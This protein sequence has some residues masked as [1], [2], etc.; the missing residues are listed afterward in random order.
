MGKSK[1]KKHQ[2]AIYV[3]DETDFE[4]AIANTNALIRIGKSTANTITANPATNTYDYI[5]QEQPET[6]VEKYAYSMEHDIA[7]YRGNADYEWAFEKFYNADSGDNAKGYAIIVFYDHEQ[8]AGVYKAF[9]A[10][11]T[12]SV[13]SADWVTGVVNVSI[14]F[15]DTP[16]TGV[17]KGSGKP[18]FVASPKAPSIVQNENSV[19]IATETDGATLLY[20]VD[21]TD[22]VAHGTEYT[23]AITLTETCTVKAAALKDDAA[24]RVIKLYCEVAATDSGDTSGTNGDNSGTASNVLKAYAI[25]SNDTI[26]V[27][28]HADIANAVF[29]A[30]EKGTVITTKTAIQLPNNAA[31]IEGLSTEG[32]K[33]T[34]GAN[35]YTV[36]NEV[37]K[38]LTADYITIEPDA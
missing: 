27:F 26:F 18:Q 37:L 23:G 32:L 35:T 28:E 12:V 6:E 9:A 34:I 31:G 36:T 21:G 17:V 20:T 2:V 7:A 13:S 22:P 11:I 4:R 24:S 30:V 33:I 29:E 10:P 38:A 14:A 25:L 3:T 19:T 15:N 5:D 16:K 8:T 1:T